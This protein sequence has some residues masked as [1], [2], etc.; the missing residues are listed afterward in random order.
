MATTK[1]SATT[2][3]LTKRGPTKAAALKSLGLTQEDLDAIKE[4]RELREGIVNENRDAEV[5]AKTGAPPQAVE[6]DPLVRKLDEDKE[7][8]EQVW[9]ARNLRNVEFRMRLGR[10]K[11]PRAPKPLQPRGQR[12]DMKKL[13][14][15][16]LNDEFLLANIELQCIEIITAAEAAKVVK[17]QSTNMQQSVHPAV[18]MLRSPTGEKIGFEDAASYVD[19]SVVV[20]ELN[21]VAGEYGEIVVNR[22]GIQ[23]TQ[24]QAPEM[25]RQLGGNPHLLS[26]GFAAERARDEVARQKN[27]E[28]PAAGGIQR[29]VVDTPKK[30]VPPKPKGV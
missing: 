15:D 10:E 13:E 5:A 29:V 30:V 27:I 22:G 12:G 9:F 2:R 17:A 7:P 20:A 18:D 25:G 4:L 1:K 24:G 19:E 21:P 28:G 23:R 11:E 6:E 16:D 3:K 14:K 26:D 8:E